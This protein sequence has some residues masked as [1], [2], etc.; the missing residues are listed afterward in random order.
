MRQEGQ[1]LYSSIDLGKFPNFFITRLV[2]LCIDWTV[3]QYQNHDDKMFVS[4]PFNFFIR[5][6]IM[7][8]VNLFFNFMI[9]L[10]ITTFYSLLKT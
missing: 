2:L 6:F 1:I 10:Y 5:D 3:S 8:Y 7:F 9:L 4:L